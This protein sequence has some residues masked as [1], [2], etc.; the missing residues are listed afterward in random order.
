M[1][2]NTKRRL[3]KTRRSV[4]CGR[5]PGVRYTDETLAEHKHT[6]AACF[7]IALSAQWAAFGNKLPEDRQE[8][9][10]NLTAKLRKR[11]GKQPMLR[12]E[13]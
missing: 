12:R 5:T 2:S 3:G 10:F 11:H 6:K 9:Q 4:E 8:H 1:N 7:S 13:S